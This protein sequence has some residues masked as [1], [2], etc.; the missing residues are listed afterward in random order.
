M[1]YEAETDMWAARKMGCRSSWLCGRHFARV[2]EH[3]S[4]ILHECNRSRNA[5]W[6]C[7]LL[8]K[9]LQKKHRTGDSQGRSAIFLM[10]SIWWDSMHSCSPS[11]MQ[12]A[13]HHLPFF[14]IVRIWCGCWYKCTEYLIF[15]GLLIRHCLKQFISTTAA[16]NPHLCIASVYSLWKS[17][18]QWGYKTDRN[19]F[20]GLASA[21]NQHQSSGFKKG[22]ELLK[23]HK[24]N[25]IIEHIVPKSPPS[26][27]AEKM[28]EYDIT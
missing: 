4:T 16:V 22:T 21:V 5:M 20:M 7:R 27:F 6:R 9:R 12:A 10:H 15:P 2:F 11:K 8:L 23:N 26:L 1:S 19:L 13:L 17:M 24:S 25:Q 3:P 28:I 14:C 18:V